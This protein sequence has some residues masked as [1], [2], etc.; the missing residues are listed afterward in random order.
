MKKIILVVILAY[1]ATLAVIVVSNNGTDPASCVA[2]G[3][4]CPPTYLQK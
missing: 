2:S 1:L 3:T 4:N